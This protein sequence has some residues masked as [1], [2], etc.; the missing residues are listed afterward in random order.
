MNRI[1]PKKLA[2]SKWTA[3]HP[4]YQQK[5]FIVTQLFYAEDDKIVACEIEAVINQQTY[6]IDWHELQ[7][8]GRWLMGWQ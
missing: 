3:V 5:H 1:N 7:D 2:L 6:T 8:S 4:Q